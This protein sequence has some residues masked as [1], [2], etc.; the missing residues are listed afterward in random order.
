MT[1]FLR[2]LQTTLV[3]ATLA[4]AAAQTVTVFAASSLTDAFT[5]LAHGFEA[6]HPGMR[7]ALD[8]AASSTLAT[9]IL[10]GAPA[11]VFASANILQMRRV[12]EAGLEAG[13]PTPFAGNRLVVVVPSGSDLRTFEQLARPRLLLVLAASQVPAGHYADEMLSA[14]TRVYGAAFVAKVRSNVVSREPNVRQTAAKVSLGAADAA[15]VYATDA[16]GLSNVRTIAIPAPLQPAIRYPLVTLRG[17]AHP[18]AASA[19]RAYV[20]SP[21]GLAALAGYGFAPPP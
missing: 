18:A 5:A 10:Q 4:F 2:W 13:P 17:S 14:A 6:T 9:Q 11:D 21:V 7:V 15:V 3:A 16:L 1:R 12:T 8:F 19:F 20:L